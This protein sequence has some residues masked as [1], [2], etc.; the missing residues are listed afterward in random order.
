MIEKYAKTCI[1]MAMV[2]LMVSAANAQAIDLEKSVSFKDH[3]F[4]IAEQIF[5]NTPNKI[6]VLAT[7]DEPLFIAT[8]NETVAISLEEWGG[9]SRYGVIIKI[10]NSSYNVSVSLERGWGTQVDEK[11]I[12]NLRVQISLMEIFRGRNMEY[13][14]IGI[15][16]TKG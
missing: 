3:N 7:L 14:R 16:I 4:F 6:S 10:S 2:V 5:N 13:A 9:D 11:V 8:K 12:G 15:F 1:A